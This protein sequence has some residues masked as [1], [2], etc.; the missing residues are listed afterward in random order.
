MW[1]SLGPTWFGSGNDWGTLV[2]NSG[3]R[4]CHPQLNAGL[5]PS[6]HF[7]ALERKSK[8]TESKT[9]TD[10]FTLEPS[11]SSHNAKAYL[12]HLDVTPRA[13]TVPFLAEFLS[14]YVQVFMYPISLV[15]ISYS[16]L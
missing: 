3:L 4:A 9:D 10:S 11:A 14:L 2:A 7:L 16:M 1:L 8:L 13:R 12:M 15:F 5:R 6:W